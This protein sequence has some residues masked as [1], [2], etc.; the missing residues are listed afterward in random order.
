MSDTTPVP[1]SATITLSGPQPP[2]S[3]SVPVVRNVRATSGVPQPAIIT[4]TLDPASANAG[5]TLGPVTTKTTS[6]DIRLSSQS[7]SQYVF[8]DDD[9]EAN[10]TFLFGFYYYRNGSAFYVDPEIDNEEPV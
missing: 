4:Y 10:E 2:Y 7:S 8:E 3:V 6:P 9:T 5:F 1:L